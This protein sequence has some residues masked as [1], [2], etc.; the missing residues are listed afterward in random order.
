MTSQ[1]SGILVHGPTG[2][3]TTSLETPFNAGTVAICTIRADRDGRPSVSDQVGQRN[4]FVLN[5]GGVRLLRDRNIVNRRDHATK[6]RM[7]VRRHSA[8]G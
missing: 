3:T 8:P 1:P 7:A 5:H 2:E 4:M 6:D